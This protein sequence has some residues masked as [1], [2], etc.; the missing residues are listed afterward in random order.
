MIKLK[1]YEANLVLRGQT[2]DNDDKVHVLK[3]H[4]IK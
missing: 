4:G 3:G 2:V 1:E